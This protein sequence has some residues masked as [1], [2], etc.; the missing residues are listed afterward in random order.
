[1]SIKSMDKIR[2]ILINACEKGYYDIFIEKFDNN[3]TYLDDGFLKNLFNLSVDN[4]QINIIKYMLDN[5]IIELLDLQL[6]DLIN[7]AISHDNYRLFQLFLIESKEI[8]DSEIMDEILKNIIQADV[9]N[10]FKFIN[11]IWEL[12]HYELLFEQACS[13]CSGR[14]MEYFYILSRLK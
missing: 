4:N 1:M 10:I 11:S 3:L 8:I 12:P 5:C 6:M 7:L 13:M 2:S 14:L 9:I